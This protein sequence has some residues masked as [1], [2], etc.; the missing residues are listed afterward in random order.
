MNRRRQP[1]QG[2]LPSRLSHCNHMRAQRLHRLRIRMVWASLGRFRM[3]DVS[4][5]CPRPKRRPGAREFLPPVNLPSV[6]ARSGCATQPSGSSTKASN[7]E[8]LPIC[9]LRRSLL[10]TSSHPSQ[11]LFWPSRWRPADIRHFA[12]KIVTW[13]WSE[14]SRLHVAS[15]SPTAV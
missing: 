3:L 12:C 8:S 13:V 5:L 6:R 7:G 2:R 9:A 1:F 10:S 11:I 4:V 14:G 15:A